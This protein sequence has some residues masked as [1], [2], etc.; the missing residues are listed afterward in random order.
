MSIVAVG[1]IALDDVVTEAG[2][3]T[4]APGGSA[5]Y[6]SAAASLFAPVHLVGVVGDDFPREEIEF[7]ERRGVNLD[8]LHVIGGGKT[9]RWS[10]EYELDM[11]KRRTTNLELNVFQDFNPVLNDTARKAPY[12]FLGNIGPELQ[13]Q[14]LDQTENP[15]FVAL[16]TMECYISG[17]SAGLCD[18]LKR[19]DLLFINDSE[20]QILTGASNLLKAGRIL[21]TMGPH[22]VIIK[23]GEHGSLLFGNDTF[24]T[25]PAYPVE[26]VADP[27][28]AGD[29]FAGAVM[30]Y[31]ARTGSTTTEALKK[32]VVYG[33]LVASF[34]VEDFSLDA[35]RD[36]TFADVEKRMDRFRAITSF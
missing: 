32:A 2:S 11:N 26:T 7:L 16:D 28:G 35:L 18:V 4:N 24:F 21:L 12:V 1:S 33:G 15:R 34:G 22:S 36:I 9:F 27:T 19:I 5:L 25:I 29:T 30:G 10:G 14:V 6:F 13:M 8:N 23:K 3:V 20:A 31:C 17:N